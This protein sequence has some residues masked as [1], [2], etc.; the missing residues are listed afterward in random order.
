VAIV[1]IV[2]F[3]GVVFVITTLA[4]VP[5]VST[6]C[7]HSMFRDR[8]DLEI[9]LINGGNDTLL[10]SADHE[11]LRADGDGGGS[12]S[13]PSSDDS[14]AD[15]GGVIRTSTLAAKDQEKHKHPENADAR[16]TQRSGHGRG[17]KIFKGYVAADRPGPGTSWY[18]DSSEVAM[19]LPAIA[20]LKKKSRARIQNQQGASK[21]A[22]KKS[23]PLHPKD[24]KVMWQGKIT[25]AYGKTKFVAVKPIPESSMT[26]KS[27][28]AYEKVV[29]TLQSLSYPAGSA[30]TKSKGGLRMNRHRKPPRFHPH[31]I[32][33]DGVIKMRLPVMLMPGDRSSSTKSSSASSA[34]SPQTKMYKCV[35]QDWAL[36]G[37]VADA[38]VAAAELRKLRR[39]RA[40]KKEAKEAKEAAKK[41]KKK[42]NP[43][44]ENRNSEDDDSGSGGGGGSGFMAAIT[45][46][47]SLGSL[48]SLSGLTSSFRSL[49]GGS[50]R[51]S[52]LE[53]L[54]FDKFEAVQWAYQVAA[55]LLYLHS[56]NMVHG[57]VKAENIL[58][59]SIK[60]P[61]G[62]ANVK[63]T[64]RVKKKKKEGE[65]GEESEKSQVGKKNDDDDD[66]DDHNTL[67]MSK[68]DNSPIPLPKCRAAKI[69]PPEPELKIIPS[70][71]PRRGMW[72]RVR[73]GSDS[74]GSARRG[75][76][77]IAESA[78]KHIVT[79]SQISTLCHIAP[80][81]AEYGKKNTPASDMWA[82]GIFLMRLFTLEPGPYPAHLSP[83]EVLEGVAE[84][85][86]R[87]YMP[88]PVEDLPH[89]NLG[90]LI[91]S[92]LRANP[93]DRITA[94]RAVVMLNEI[95]LDETQKRQAPREGALFSSNGGASSSA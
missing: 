8:Q 25:D 83:A 33:V 82:F 50:S 59:S 24:I 1:A 56:K 69:C 75:A 46:L 66:N 2:V 60:L 44:G 23:P 70:T 48:S 84:Q 38:I 92:C 35:V 10:L 4:L 40:V 7:R 90:E 54:A 77:K 91:L 16:N 42:M 72:G 65:E 45:S 94:Q 63:A 51:E 32:K 58:L 39:K 89:E 5:V 29:R 62:A 86:L 49:S 22:P 6:Y 26:T 80:E 93:S 37:S 12:S 3:G 14:D 71:K 73:S 19:T 27:V 57:N 53:H 18:M 85:T 47:S 78:T 41:K 30:A 13:D 28:R 31:V 74:S 15:D 81:I 17:K 87:P 64:E 11:A 79:P 43:P 20:A 95:V 9:G 61:P 55:A 21:R 36:G 68:R 67:K 88:D 76:S 52:A 34:A